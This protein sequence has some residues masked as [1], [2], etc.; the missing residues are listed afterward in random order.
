MII[1]FTP[2]L[3]T[4]I[5]SAHGS[6]MASILGYDKDATG[7]RVYTHPNDFQ[8]Q[9]ACIEDPVLVTD[10]YRL[11][12]IKPSTT[13]E[14][15]LALFSS[16]IRITKYDGTEVSFEQRK[17][18]GV[19][20]PSIDTVLFCQAVRDN[21]DTLGRTEK[22]IEI[23]CGSGFISKYMLEHFPELK[24]MTLVDFNPLAISCAMGNIQDQR[25]IYHPGDAIRFLA[26]KDHKYDVIACNPP[27][28]PRPK[29]IDDNAYEGVGL[30]VYLIQESR[31]LL[32]EGGSLVTNISNLC[33]DIVKPEVERVG[34]KMD[35]LKELEVP[36]K[37]FNVLNNREWMQYLEGRGLKKEERQGY[38][39]WQRLQIVRIKPQ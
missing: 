11:A 1:E 16:P 28:I 29:S 32:R 23:G 20:G 14:T 21:L 35:V 3:K 31:R 13:R 12:Q 26:D 9:V 25:A 2:D 18:P 7:R 19:W 27:Y 39:Y 5:L 17:Y 34:A 36:L 33:L 15:A 22:A 8:Q 10:F 24:S 37:V 30:L 38:D 4:Q 6:E